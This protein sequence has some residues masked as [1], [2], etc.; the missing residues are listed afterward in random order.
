MS[1]FFGAF[2]WIVWISCF[3]FVIFYIVHKVKFIT[4]DSKKFSKQ[5][6]EIY[7]LWFSNNYLDVSV[8]G[9]ADVDAF[10]TCVNLS[11]NQYS[12]NSRIKKVI[13]G[14]WI[15]CKNKINIQAAKISW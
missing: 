5:Q 6:D 13:P 12:E 14:Y 3:G 11:N 1:V 2:T 15:K 4:I 9:P 10:A 7:K 8:I